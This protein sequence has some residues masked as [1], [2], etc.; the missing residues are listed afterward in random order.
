MSVRQTHKADYDWKHSEE[1]VFAREQEAHPN[2]YKPYADSHKRKSDL[3]ADGGKP[4]ADKAGGGKN[5][6][7]A[8]DLFKHM[9]DDQPAAADSRKGQEDEKTQAKRKFDDGDD[10]PKVEQSPHAEKSF[11]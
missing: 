9:V 7:A 1:G 5:P 2:A 6:A 8:M 11:Q 4:E 10:G 3:D